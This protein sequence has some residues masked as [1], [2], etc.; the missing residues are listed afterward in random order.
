MLQGRARPS[1][2]SL[3]DIEMPEMNGFEFAE[4]LRGDPRTADLPMIALSSV[5]SAGGDRAWPSGR[6]PRLRRQIRPARA[7]RRAQGAGRRRPCGVTS[8]TMNAE[9]HPAGFHRIRHRDDRRPA[10]RAADRARA[11]RLHSGAADAGSAGAAGNCRR[12]QS[13]RP[14]RHADRSAP[15]LRARP[16][17]ERP[18]RHGD[19]RRI[20]GPNP[21][22]C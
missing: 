6:V 1:M 12:A 7:D 2:W 21:T 5:V 10:V 19:R 13:A 3:T 17:R 9:Q 20:C 11:G 16:A 14:Y 15:P 4:R 8:K 18:S 22:A